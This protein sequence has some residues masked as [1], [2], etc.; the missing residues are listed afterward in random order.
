ML[1]CL[2][3][4]RTGQPVLEPGSQFQNWAAMLSGSGTGQSARLGQNIYKLTINIPIVTIGAY[5]VY[6]L[7]AV[8]MV[9]CFLK[10]KSSLKNCMRGRFVNVAF[11]LRGAEN[12][13]ISSATR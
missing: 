4:S 6:T 2:F 5:A 3:S 12:A 11:F 7:R 13:S 1:T 9:K 8:I 10:M